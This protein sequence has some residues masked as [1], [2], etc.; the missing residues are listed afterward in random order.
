MNQKHQLGCLLV[1]SVLLAGNASAF[2]NPSTG[3]WLNRDPIGQNGGRNENGFLKNDSANNLD[4][5]GTFV[6]AVNPLVDV[7]CSC[8]C[9]S[10]GVGFHP[11]G[12][13]GFQWGWNTDRDGPWFGNKMAVRWYVQGNPKFC[14]Y[15][16]IEN[17]SGVLMHTTSVSAP[18][19]PL[20]WGIFG[21]PNDRLMN[22]NMTSA[23]YLKDGFAYTDRV[24]HTSWDSPTDDGDWS[25]TVSQALS[26][27]LKCVS[28]DKV[29]TKT[30]PVAIPTPPAVVRFPPPTIP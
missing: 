13:A 10:V 6:A 2:Y 21:S 3:R 19:K 9:M 24:G 1:C 28:S 16:Q 12:R 30:S 29:T 5:H 23:L 15:R 17:G 25:F 8:K 18:N 11:G 14:E 20:D 7:V 4:L 26:I 22:G 27:T